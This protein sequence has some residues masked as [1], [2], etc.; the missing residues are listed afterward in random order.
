M[1][2]CKKALRKTAAKMINGRAC[3]SI[4]VSPDSPHKKLFYLKKIYYLLPNS[5][6]VRT[7]HAL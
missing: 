5:G 3:K 4:S 2:I 7:P 1:L 6:C